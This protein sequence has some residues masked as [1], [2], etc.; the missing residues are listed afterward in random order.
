MG[1]LYDPERLTMEQFLIDL[2]ERIVEI[3]PLW[4]YSLIFLFTWLENI[5]PPIPGDVIVV[6]GGYVAATGSLDIILVV[7]ISTIGAVAGFMC[8]YYAG[9][10]AGM[11][12]LESRWMQWIPREPIVRV[13]KWMQRWGYGLIAVNRF[14]SVARAVISLIVGISRIPAGPVALFA[15]LSALLWTTLLGVLGY[16]IGSEW[17]L[18]LQYL[19]RYSRI[20]SVLILTF[21]GWQLWKM[22]RRHQHRKATAKLSPPEVSQSASGGD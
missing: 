6:F 13:T 5:T 22:I 17:E 3:P 2:A 18:I 7:A 20:I 21:L 10:Y 11:A 4:A 15:T 12:V 8:M 19:D 14:L 9:R 16:F 1:D